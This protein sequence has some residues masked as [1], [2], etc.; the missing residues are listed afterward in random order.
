MFDPGLPLKAT[1]LEA[2]WPLLGR[3]E[4]ATF[5]DVGTA[6]EAVEEL[7]LARSMRSR[8]V[9]HGG[10]DLALLV[11][12]GFAAAILGLFTPVA[13]GWLI[14]HAIP[15]NAADA[16]QN[17]IAGLAVAGVSIIALEAL[18]ALAVMRFEARIGVAMQAALVD[19][20][21]SAPARFFR[22]FA[23]GDLALR[24]GSV[25]TIQRTITGSTI[26]AFVTSLFLLANL[27]LMIAYSPALTVAAAGIVVLVIAVSTAIGLARLRIG[28]RIEALDGKLSAMT[29]EIFSGIAKLR[30][31]AAESRAFQQ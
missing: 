17:V 14:D 2:A 4:A 26:G 19:R 6:D 7:A 27:A 1:T 31:S 28:P 5:P 30:A 12:A 18:R 29:F 25:N 9:I 10:R 24:M 21:I 23:S 8:P 16:V 13:T 20:V 15:S 11:L 22:E 3:G